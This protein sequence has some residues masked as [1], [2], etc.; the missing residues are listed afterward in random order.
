MKPR[1]WYVM[2]VSAAPHVR[3]AIEYGH[4]GWRRGNRD[5]RYG[6]G[7]E[8]HRLFRS[9]IRPKANRK[10]PYRRTSHLPVHTRPEASIE[11]PA[12][13][14]TRLVSSMEEA[15]ARYRGQAL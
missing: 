4:G 9:A 8:D 5:R 10:D 2:E 15:L 11:R 13:R 7:S 1:Q 12:D 3:E 6:R 14:R